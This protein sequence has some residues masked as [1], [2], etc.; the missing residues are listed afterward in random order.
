M[1]FRLQ[2]L[3]TDASDR[4]IIF[5]H[6][7][8]WVLFIFYEISFIYFSTGQLSHPLSYVIFYGLNMALFYVNAGFILPF[9][10]RSAHH[11]YFSCA[12]S[13]IIEL[14][15][16]LAI[17][18][19]LDRL[20]TVIAQGHSREVSVTTSYL[21]VNLWR[22]LYFVGFSTAYWLI[23]RAMAFRKRAADA[24]RVQLTTLKEN[25]E[26]GRNL[27]EAKNAYLQH[28]INP[29]FLFNTL[30]FIYNTYRKL[31]FQAAECVL[32]LVEIMRYTAE[33]GEIDGKTELITEIEQIQNFIALNQLRFDYQLYIDFEVKG[34]FDD[35]RII[36]LILLTLTENIFKHGYLKRK[37]VP[38]KL[39]IS[40]DE[41][42]QLNF[43]SWNLKKNESQNKRIRSIGIKNVIKRL[44]YSYKEQY[45]L[46][47]KDDADGFGVE[48][49][50][51]L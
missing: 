28:Q 7:A 48:L 45:S 33:E 39:Y 37:A 49:K 31:S 23:L 21:F 10:F 47:I 18:Y 1:I 12:G 44:D 24:E 42:G 32:L 25:A 36:P 27:A 22:G 2:S 9:S 5:Y 11:R 16:Y 8:G 14:V 15:I 20:L 6:V 38:A 50:I 26:L 19:W 41:V 13:I 40:L 34:N 3:Y 51:R 30:T 29:H 4:K 43:V 17:K 35:C 46:H